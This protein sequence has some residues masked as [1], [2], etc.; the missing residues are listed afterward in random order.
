MFWCVSA[1]IT[2]SRVGLVTLYEKMDM[3]PNQIEMIKK[4]GILDGNYMIVVT[5]GGCVIALGAALLLD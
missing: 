4:S 2:F 1:S 3:P 5:I